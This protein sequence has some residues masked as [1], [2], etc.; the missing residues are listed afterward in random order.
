MSENTWE[1]LNQITIL[2][3]VEEAIQKPLS[4]VCLQRNS[5]INRVYEVE[6]AESKERLIAKFYRPR[7]W[8]VDMIRD[9][10]ALLFKLKAEELPVVPPLKWEGETVFMLENIPFAIFPKMG[11][12]AIDEFDEE[13]WTQAGRLIGRLHMI[14][15]RTSISNRIKWIPSIATASHLETLKT[16]SLI[17]EKFREP[18]F[19]ISNMFVEKATTL[20]ASTSLFPIHGDVHLGNFIYRPDEGIYLVDFDD[21]CIGPAV[22]DLWMLLPDIPE[23]C[24][25]ELDWFIEGYETFHEFPRAS[26]SLVPALRAMRLIHFAAWC[27]V[28]YNDPNFTYY[29]PEWGDTKY[30]NETTRT[31]QSI[32]YGELFPVPLAEKTTELDPEFIF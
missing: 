11:G 14:S 16:S 13:L 4:N 7:R 22:Q 17:P 6:V 27:S 2:N 23:H 31:I 12:R 24:E 10:H 15:S 21:A 26:L 20:F 18:F 32:V 5:Y 9:E 28:Q 25:K 30:W 3:E 19:S 8:T 1:N 29:F